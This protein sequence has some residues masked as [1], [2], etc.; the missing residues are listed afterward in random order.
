M[1]N[2]LVLLFLALSVQANAQLGRGLVI[3]EVYIGSAGSTDQYI[4]IYNPQTTTQYLDGC[5]IVQFGSAG[6]TLS[7]TTLSGATTGW[8]F[9]GRAGGK[10]LAV[11]SKEFV[12][13]AASA[14]KNAGG[15]DLT[16]AS[17]EAR[18]S[19]A[20]PNPNA[21]QLTNMSPAMT[22]PGLTPSATADAIALTNGSD[23]TITDGVNVSSV[24]DA[25]QYNSSLVGNFPNT[26]D[27]GTTGGP[28][29]KAGF[30]LER[31]SVGVTTHD[32][33]KDFSL[34][35]PTPGYEHGGAPPPPV[36][37]TPTLL[38]PFD[39]NRFVALDQFDTVTAGS[40]PNKYRSSQTIVATGLSFQG[41][42]DV[43]QL[44][45]SSYTSGSSSHVSNLHLRTTT[46]GDVQVFADAEMLNY[47]LPSNLASSFTPPNTWIDYVKMSA[48]VG[49]SYPMS[50][51]TGTNSG[52][53]IK[54]TF[55]G[56]YRGIERVTVPRATFDS[57]FRFDLS[58]DVQISESGFQLGSFTI[59]N[60]TYYARGIGMIRQSNPRSGTTI[61][62]NDI[63]VDG[64]E[65]EM[66][67]Y[68]I[69]GQSAV[70]AQPASK[71]TANVYPNPASSFL[72]FATARQVKSVTLYDARGA[73]VLSQPMD[74][75]EPSISVQNLPAGV[76]AATLEYVDGSSE[77]VQVV[78]RR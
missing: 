78:L 71:A 10:T 68:G 57:S 53:T 69:R 9:P 44:R 11:K 70:R 48:G 21:T 60:A 49:V 33:Y 37:V 32:S 16:A 54:I 31:N 41:S 72:H 38:M 66:T 34:Q 35:Y 4:E 12:I 62:G 65:K 17:Y 50:T 59:V 56:K 25:M 3:N 14:K 45:D 6:G 63:P 39:M 30:A 7:G 13:V 55:S 18:S 42:T 29:L 58:G 24:L 75:T 46:A 73:E 74:A 52:A 2:V 5:M 77:V 15:L 23:A 36:V 20:Q 8:K 61:L 28:N 67:T 76:Y 64:A 26:I 1:K 27:S 19:V 40:A 47:I 22:Y 51:I 43:A